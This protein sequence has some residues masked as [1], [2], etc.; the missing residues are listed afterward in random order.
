MNVRDGNLYLAIRKMRQT[1]L[2]IG[3]LKKPKARIPRRFLHK[4]SLAQ[5]AISHEGLANR[6]AIRLLHGVGIE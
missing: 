6:A 1:V 2:V 5:A 4:P 3:H